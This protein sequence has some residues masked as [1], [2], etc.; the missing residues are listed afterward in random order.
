PNYL[1][2]ALPGLPWI[3]L[4]RLFAFPATAVLLVCISISG[5]FRK[6]LSSAYKN[7]PILPISLLVFVCI[8]GL[9]IVTSKEKA[10][11]LQKFFIDQIYWSIMYVISTYVFLK[12]GR[13]EKWAALLWATIAPISLIAFRENQ[14]RHVI[15]AGH[16]PGFLKIEDKNIQMVLA[17]IYRSYTNIYRVQ[18][19]AS[20]SL[21]LSEYLAILLPFVIHF[22]VGP[23]SRRTKGLAVFSI[24]VI[25]YVILISGSRL[26]VLGFGL[27]ALI[28]PLIWAILK[29][30]RERGG[31]LAPAIVLAY[32]AVFG[33]AIAASL[34]IGRI[35][36]AV[37]GGG[38]SQSSTDSR[39]IQIKM[40]IPKILHNPFGY[41]VGQGADTLGYYTPGG[42]LTIDTY[43]LLIALEYGVIGFIVYYGMI[44]LYIYYSGRY[45]LFERPKERE[46]TLTIPAFISLVNFF[47]IKSAFSQADNHPLIFM[48]MGMV[49]ALCYRIRLEREGAAPSARRVDRGQ[50]A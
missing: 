18:A 19:T 42:M 2:I 47:I 16:I 3:T 6:S 45:S 34:V 21:G 17:G 30:K 4:V 43:Y 13:A 35:R 48:I 49:V 29:W 37:W 27:S 23:Y 36:K 46:L 40:G 7:I 25:L 50:R 1:A 28:Y 39:M 9:S 33:A 10:D 24:P 31:L 22:A 26:G 15:W 44:G 5:S 12:P 32:P 38:A 8:Q 11:S 14:L 41:G 20:T